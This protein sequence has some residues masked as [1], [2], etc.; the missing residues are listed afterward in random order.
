VT[1]PAPQVADLE[2]GPSGGST[3]AM[4][5]GGAGEADAIQIH[6]GCE[7]AFALSFY[8]PPMASGEPE[9]D[10]P[11]V[12]L[13]S[14]ASDN[15]TFGLLLGDYPGEE[16]VSGGRG[17]WASGEAM[18]GD[19]FLAPVAEGVWHQAIVRLKASSR[20]EGFYEVYLDGQPIDA[21]SGVSPI[22]PGSS[23][24]QVEVGPGDTLEPI[25]P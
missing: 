13:V 11:I 21:R 14:D 10:V 15:R 4:G 19:R 22:A 12:Q 6:E 1:A 7:Y 17:L 9:A 2:A 23:Y 18:G 25:L 8:I 16:W 20:E 24:A 3:A 5:E